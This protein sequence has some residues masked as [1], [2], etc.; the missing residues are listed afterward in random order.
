VKIKDKEKKT[1][2]LI[3]IKESINKLSTKIESDGVSYC[4]IVK[5]KTI[6]NSYITDIHEENS[7][8]Y[9]FK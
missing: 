9:N 6:L 7:Q 1:K 3:V 2:S 8:K 5:F 4:N